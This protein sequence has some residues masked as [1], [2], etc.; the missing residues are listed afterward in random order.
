MGAK[1][2]S[3]YKRVV[4]TTLVPKTATLISVSNAQDATKDISLG[5]SMAILMQHLETLQAPSVIVVALYLGNK[6]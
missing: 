2:A 1:L 4:D 3:Q 5:D 6:A